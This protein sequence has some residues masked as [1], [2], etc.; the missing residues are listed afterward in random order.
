[1]QTAP[2]EKPSGEAAE[3]ELS[4]GGLRWLR[5]ANPTAAGLVL[6]ALVAAVWSGVGW[7]RAEWFTA[8][9]RDHAREA[10]LDAARQA[11]VNLSSMNPDDVDGSLSQMRSVLTGDMLSDF[12]TNLDRIK[13]AAAQSHTR[14]E[15]HVLGASLVKLDSERAN[16]TALVVLAQT[17]TDPGRQPVQQRVT[18]TVD[19]TDNSAGWKAD[20]AN[21]LGQ[22][23]L[24]DSPAPGNPPQAVPGQPDPNVNQ[25]GAAAPGPAA[26]SP[27]PSS[28]PPAAPSQSGN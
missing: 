10:A 15:S 26:Q 17:E 23:V 12:D 6:V 2:Y 1:M 8:I 9:P 5:W 14:L 21:S 22:P 19:L 11:A 28:P 7:T 18:W 4:E 20:N 24:L 16:A 27:A 25:P 3:P 13:D